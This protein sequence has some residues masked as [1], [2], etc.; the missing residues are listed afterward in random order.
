MTD[1]S[2]S[3]NIL[4]SVFVANPGYE[5]VLFDRLPAEQREL[6]KDLQKDPD[7]Y[8]VLRPLEKASM[9]VKAISRDTAL[10][11]LTLRQPGRFPEYARMMLGERCNQEIT[12]LVLD[13]VLAL[14][15]AGK[16]ISGS[17]AAALI[18]GGS[19]ELAAGS[20][21]EGFLERLSLKAL[22]YGQS[23][24]L[25]DRMALSMR[26]YGYNRAPLS[27]YWKQTLRDA[28]AVAEFLGI[29]SGRNQELLDREW[30]DAAPDS[31]GW[32]TW[33]SRRLQTRGSFGSRIAIGPKLYVSPKIHH[34]PEVLPLVLN[35]LSRTRVRQF[36]I[37]KDAAGLLRPDKMVAYFSGYDDLMDTAEEL[38]RELG[39]CAAQGVPFTAEL[40]ADGLLSWG[41]DPP[42]EGQVLPWVGLESWRLWVTNRLAAA[43]IAARID[44]SA[45]ME[46]WQFAMRRLQL[47]GVDTRSWVPAGTDRT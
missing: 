4:D 26:L 16:L 27:P 14:E 28:D 11:F 23:L 30:L 33:Q 5:L 39:G 19:E 17:E 8:G 12:R 41:V 21:V 18:C 3:K 38:K 43:L 47:E 29:R 7:F 15:R 9:G 6:L 22:K 20:A 1:S 32:L 36:K 2:S 45:S 25:T 42:T 31:D 37:G 40:T 10:L 44:D 34:L 46:P 35:V 13:G 24:G